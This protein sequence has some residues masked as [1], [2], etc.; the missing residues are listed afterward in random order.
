M[1]EKKNIKDNNWIGFIRIYKYL[2]DFLIKKIKKFYKKKNNT[3][4]KNL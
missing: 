3:K 1:F 4:L 2:P